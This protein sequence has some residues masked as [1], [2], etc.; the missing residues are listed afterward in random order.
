MLSFSV[1]RKTGEFTIKGRLDAD[2][3][4]PSQTG[5]STLLLDGANTQVAGDGG[6]R[7]SVNLFTKDPN[8][9]LG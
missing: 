9:V 7:G 5:K 3:F 4:R 2:A 1:D 6:V 8:G